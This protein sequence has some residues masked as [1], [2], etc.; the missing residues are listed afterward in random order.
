MLVLKND[1]YARSAIQLAVDFDLGIVI[2][3]AVFYDG[4]PK[5]GPADFLGVAFINAEEAFK[6][7]L[8]IF[9]R[10]S[11]SSILHC[12]GRSCALLVDVDRNRSA[13]P[14]VFYRIIT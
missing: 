9:L 11:D 1:R 5:A 4:Q 12:H 6:D 8:Q 13:I 14:V 7:S 3:G 10:D 2:C